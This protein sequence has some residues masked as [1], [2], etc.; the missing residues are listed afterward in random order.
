MV[1]MGYPQPSS[2]RSSLVS[3]NLLGLTHMDVQKQ[4]PGSSKAKLMP[5][6]SA[7]DH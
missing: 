3:G 4:P 1:E 5:E 6:L 2:C 7:E